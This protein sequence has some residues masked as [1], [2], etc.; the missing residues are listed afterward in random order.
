MSSKKLNIKK[1]KALKKIKS[2]VSKNLDLKKIKVNPINVI[3][4]TKDKIGNF[5]SNI[6]KRERKIKKELKRKRF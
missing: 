2:L 5:Y 6:K 1:T 3:E 4:K